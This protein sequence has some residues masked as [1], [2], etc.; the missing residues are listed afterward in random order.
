M[1]ILFIDDFMSFPVVR[2][3]LTVS[4]TGKPGRKLHPLAKHG[5]T[6]G[7]PGLAKYATGCPESWYSDLEFC[8]RVMQSKLSSTRQG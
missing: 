7:H 6:W 4:Q 3:S 8:R 1:A 2:I 5:L